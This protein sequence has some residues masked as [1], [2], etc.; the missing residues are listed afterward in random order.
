MNTGPSVSE[1]AVV[2]SSVKHVTTSSM[3]SAWSRI[4]IDQGGWRELGH[5][6]YR[7][8]AGSVNGSDQ[9]YVQKGWTMRC[10]SVNSAS[11]QCVLM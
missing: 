11:L 1:L 5:S 2:Y 3:D 6:V 4:P 7:A 9:S 10:G 8:V